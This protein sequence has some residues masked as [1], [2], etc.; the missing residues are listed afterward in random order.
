M[1]F[2][3]LYQ[4]RLQLPLIFSFSNTEQCILTLRH[5]QG[6]YVPPQRT[7]I[8]GDTGADIDDK[9]EGREDGDDKTEDR[10]DKSDQDR[11]QT[12]EANEAELEL[13]CNQSASEADID[14]DQP[15]RHSSKINR[16]YF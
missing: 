4:V 7:D 6:K 12:T 5:L 14:L 15:C 8:V 16:K 11:D 1:G 9:T 13:C 10:D 3:R 2:G